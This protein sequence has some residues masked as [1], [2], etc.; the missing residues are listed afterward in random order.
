MESFKDRGDD[1]NVVYD[2]VTTP[3]GVYDMFE[4]IVSMVCAR[5]QN[6]KFISL[7]KYRSFSKT[8]FDN[9]DRKCAGGSSAMLCKLM[10]VATVSTPSY[11]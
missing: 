6:L 1:T 3:S 11:K 9:V 7:F 10:R 4:S 5:G 2:I 8:E